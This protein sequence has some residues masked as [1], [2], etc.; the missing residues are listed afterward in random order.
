MACLCLPIARA[1]PHQSTDNPI[2]GRGDKM[3]TSKIRRTRVAAAVAGIACAGFAWSPAL[4]QQLPVEP[5][6]VTAAPPLPAAKNFAQDLV[7]RT[8]ARHSELL[9]L[10]VHAKPAGGGVVSIIASKNALRIGHATDR[11]DL[12]VLKTGNPFVEINQSGNQNVEVHLPL[13]SISRE[14]V[15][16]VEMTFPYP[17]GTGFDKDALLQAAEIIR[18]EMARSILEPG[19]LVEPVRVDPRVPLDTYAQ[20][21][22]DDLL[23]RHPQLEVIAIHARLPSGGSDYPIVASNI[24]RIGKPADQADLDVIASGTP[25]VERD[26]K[27]AR[28]E[29]KLPLQDASGATIGAVA[30]V[31]PLRA[32]TDEASVARQAER[33]RNELNSRIA[34]LEKLYAPRPVEPARQAIVEAER[35]INQV[36]LGNK[37]S[38]PMT[39]E[40]VSA[41]TLQNAEGYSDAVKN[42]AGVAPSS[43]K[44]SPSDTI[45]IRGINLNP[46]SNY[47]INGGL[48]VA[49]VMTVP[50]E[51]KERLETLKGANALMF[52][53]ASPAGIINLV[54]KRAG[55][56]P[57]TTVSVAGSS[58]GQ[59]F[60]ALDVGRRFGDQ[61]QVGLRA[62]LSTAHLENG[63]HGASGHGELA[64]LGADWK[65][66]ERLSFSGDLEYY[67]K[68]TI[69][70]AT[71]SLLAPVNG[72]VPVPA[73]PAPRNLLS[74]SWAT[75]SGDTTNL[76]GRADF[77][78][79]DNWKLIGEVG[80]SDSDRSR[81]VTRIGKYNPVTGTGGVVTVSEQDQRYVNKFVRTEALGKFTTFALKHD[82]TVG[83]SQSERDAYT[84]AQNST[85]LPQRQNLYDP[86]VLNPP[87]F[88]RPPTTLP[89]Q[90][91]SDLGL[92]TYDTI[93]IG[94]AARLLLGFRRTLSKQ[95]N[96]VTQSS[97]TVNSPAGGFLYDLSP[98]TTLFASYMKGLEDGAVAPVNAAN[99][100]EILAPGI[101]DQKEI[102]LR[103]S[104]FKGL[105]ISASYFVISRVN[106]VIDPVTNVF[107]NNGRI[108]YKGA[109]SVIAYDIN[110]QWTINAAGQ[111]LHAVQQADDPTINGLAPENTPK[112][113]GNLFVTY[114]TPFL[115]GLTLT[116]GVSHFTERFVN[117]QNQGTIPG[118]T[119][120]SAGVG[121][122]TTLGGHRAS[123]QLN[124]DNVANT[125]YWNSAQQ[126]TYGT[127]MDRSIK[128]NAKFD[129]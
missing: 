91:S 103:N 15:G 108:E 112:F 36:A 34:S 118:Y 4:A 69:L 22:V 96:G 19:S 111:V 121:Y 110:R 92:Y 10:D 100:N 27:G 120:Y 14:I 125:R 74:G 32:T 46:I 87:T 25:K 99:A 126:G 21:L 29:A 75:F 82:L 70:Q 47:R 45:S 104:Y 11:D 67:R 41:G 113:I 86:I 24:G 35:E 98:T 128:L 56:A 64:S 38:L 78:V 39:K 93:G 53:I 83:V 52:G 26:A 95:D 79:N 60:G 3:K 28:I 102:G 94:P 42:Q 123:V 106:A 33:I 48:A 90:K 63:V 127:G 115:L 122:A 73:V 2:R 117:P 17:S 43:S 109:E 62:N 18:D 105:S 81:F 97:A 31:F 101:S 68:A 65:A 72:V 13:L 116:A 61:E 129:F 9:E 77:I 49:G 8:V 37:Q 59:T 44:G 58:F 71:V 7:D 40:V 5:Q 51:D 76:Q 84:L 20:F 1:D 23:A 124:V 30:L 12:D 80:R 88:A 16:V 66:T 50:T 114:R 54:T 55:A 85:T 57:V 107:S 89:L 6:A 119:L